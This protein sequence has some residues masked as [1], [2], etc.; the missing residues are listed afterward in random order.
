MSR[1]VGLTGRTIFDKML[2]FNRATGPDHAFGL[3]PVIEY[4]DW[5]EEF[6]SSPG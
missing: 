3:R 1:G 6:Y 5:F 4:N 2:S